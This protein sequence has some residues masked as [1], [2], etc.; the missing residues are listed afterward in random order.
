MNNYAASG[1]QNFF[2]KE[3]LFE[4]NHKIAENMNEFIWREMK[5]IVGWKAD[6]DKKRL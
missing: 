3:T 6:E 1:N 2:K 5:S 4:F